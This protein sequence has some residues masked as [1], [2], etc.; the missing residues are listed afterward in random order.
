MKEERVAASRIIRPAAGGSTRL[1]NRDLIDAAHDALYSSVVCAYAQGLN[2]IR[3]ASQE[4]SWGVDLREAARIWTGGCI[5]RAKL[6]GDLMRA[7]GKNPDLPSLFLDDGLN[8]ELEGAQP[9]WRGCRWAAL[10]VE[11]C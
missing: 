3:A 8:R 10:G 11:S 7:Y 9:G 1:K 2:L 6:L 5:I 4:Y